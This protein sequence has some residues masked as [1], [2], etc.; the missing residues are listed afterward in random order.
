[1]YPWGYEPII[2]SLTAHTLSEIGP[3]RIAQTKVR[4]IVVNRVGRKLTI[5]GVIAALLVGGLAAPASATEVE[6][7][8]LTPVP[9][10][11]AV[12]S[13]AQIAEL[14]ALYESTD[15]ASRTFD[16]AAAVASGATEQ[17]TADYASVLVAEGWAVQGETVEP[18]AATQ[19]IASALAACTGRSGY[20]GY[21]GWGWQW[22]LN[23]CQ[24][25]TLIAAV[26]LGAGGATAVGAVFAAIGLI[27][28]AAPVAVPVAVVSG[29]VAAVIAY[30]SLGLNVC[31]TASYGVHAIYLNLYYT[32]VRCWGQ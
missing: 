14:E 4:D 27:P 22:G 6:D 15:S 1:M 9:A 20:T 13:E 12:L 32:S 16:A 19:S 7:P 18:T 29:A 5:G 23:S 30:G 28:G 31:K 10:A 2:C 21:Y 24:T 25:D 17:G 3:D 8:E 11:E 26:N